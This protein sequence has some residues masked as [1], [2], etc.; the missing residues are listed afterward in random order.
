MCSEVERASQSAQ[1]LL[2]ELS[3]LAPA[4]GGIRADVQRELATHE[5]MLSTLANGRR[6]RLDNLEMAVEV[7]LRPLQLERILVNLVKNASLHTEEGAAIGVDAVIFDELRPLAMRPGVVL[8]PGRWVRIRVSDE[9]EGVAPTQVERLL[10]AGFTTRGSSGGS[11]L[12]LA[13]CRG[14]VEGV[15]GLVDMDGE[16]GVGCSVSLFLPTETVASTTLSGIWVIGEGLPEGWPAGVPERQLA[17]EEAVRV[18]L[19]PAGRGPRTAV[20]SQPDPPLAARLRRL[21]PGTEV[22]DALEDPTAM[23]VRLEALFATRTAEPVDAED[24]V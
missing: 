10:Q 9:G 12:G 7:G 5:T 14:L 1:E 11:G 8:P 4:P 18:A 17:R 21:W 20:L 3:L 23:R 6:L 19:Q 22:V 24:S 13:V 2:A 15:G 16:L